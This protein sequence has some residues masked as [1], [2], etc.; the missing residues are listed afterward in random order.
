VDRV[1][2]KHYACEKEGWDG[3]E[4]TNK[5]LVHREEAANGLAF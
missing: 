4:L 3:G 5:K 1:V 2:F